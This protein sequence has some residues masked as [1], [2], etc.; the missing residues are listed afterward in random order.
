MR[1]SRLH[2]SGDGGDAVDALVTDR[3]LETLLEGAD[4][5]GPADAQA[6]TRLAAAADTDA[7]GGAH[8]DAAP[9]ANPG[10]VVAPDLDPD[11]R[12]AGEV[13]RATFL[14]VHPSFRFEE[15][16]AERLADLAAATTNRPAAA[17]G[18][19]RSG[20]V[21]PFPFPATGGSGPSARDPLLAA[22]LDGTLDPTDEAAVARAAGLRAPGRP[23][24]VGGAITSAAISLVG[25]AWVAWRASRPGAAPMGRAARAAHARRLAGLASGVPG[26]PT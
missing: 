9:D 20:E 18:G 15:R 11:L 25:V 17:A 21:I 2:G 1:P 5:P 23:L 24:I 8:V 13:V 10:S 6:P 3:Y 19:A 14:R 7:D 12:R 4:T 26:G 22:V 16:L